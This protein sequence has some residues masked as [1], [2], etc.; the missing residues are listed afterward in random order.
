MSK[1]NL[2]LHNWTNWNN[3]HPSIFTVF[4][5]QMWMKFAFARCKTAKPFNICTVTHTS[6]VCIVILYQFNTRGLNQELAT[7]PFLKNSL[8]LVCAPNSTGVIND[9]PTNNGQAHTPLPRSVFVYA[10]SI[11]LYIHLEYANE[12]ASSTEIR[13]IS[14]VFSVHAVWHIIT[15]KSACRLRGLLWTTPKRFPAAIHTLFSLVFKKK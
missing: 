3:T 15:P 7:F 4:S 5:I 13:N 8:Q 14:D 10:F 1:H 2:L 11:L 12:T 9:A 6:T